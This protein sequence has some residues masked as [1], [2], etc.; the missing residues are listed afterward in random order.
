[1]GSGTNSGRG[2]G[3]LTA[4]EKAKITRDIENHSTSSNDAAERH[5][6]MYI[7]REQ[8]VIDNYGLYVRTGYI[9]DKS[10]PW[11]QGHE[12]SLAKLKAQY[13][14]FRKERKRLGK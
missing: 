14:H 7:S 12:E 3:T 13:S 10:D 6:K 2:R 5:Y 11:W 9:R 8:G 4:N 1:M